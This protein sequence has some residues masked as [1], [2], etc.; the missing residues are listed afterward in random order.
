MAFDALLLNQLLGRDITSGEE[1][2]GGD[3]LCEQRARGQS[4]V[5][6]GERVSRE[7][8]KL[9][10]ASTRWGKTHQRSSET[11]ILNDLATL[12]SQLQRRLRWVNNWDR[13][14]GTSKSPVRRQ[15][16]NFTAGWEVVG[17]LMKISGRHKRTGDGRWALDG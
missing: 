3:A 11:T 13:G 7:T 5:V 14:P 4:G 1:H 16:Q 2:G 15:T 8:S 6:P 12:Q 10:T 17:W 9:R